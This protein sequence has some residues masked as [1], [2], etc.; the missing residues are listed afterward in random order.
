MTAANHEIVLLRHGK[1]EAHF[2]GSDFDRDLTDSGRER[3]ANIANYMREQLLHPDIILSS[4]ARRAIATADIVC[5]AF[6]LDINTVD[7]RADLYEADW[8]D[9]LN[10]VQ[11][12]PDT[13]M[14]VLLVGHNPAFEDLVEKLIPTSTEDMHLSPSSM[15]RLTFKG[16]WSGLTSGQCQ[17]LS[18][19]HA[20]ELVL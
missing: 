19:K 8:H 20:Q 13:V 10:I 5:A 12:L 16:Q 2:H 1:A 9:V 11:Q 17:L 7:V 15:A 3:T 4:S 6:V 18:I 14:R